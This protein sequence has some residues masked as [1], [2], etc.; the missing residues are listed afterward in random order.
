MNRFGA[1]IKQYLQPVIAGLFFLVLIVGSSGCSNP[2]MRTHLNAKP[3]LSL[4]QFFAGQTVAYGIFEDRF[5]ALKR[6]FRVQITGTEADGKLILDEDFL[7]DDGEQAKRVWTITPLGEDENGFTQY[8]GEAGD[9]KGFAQ[10]VVAGNVLNWS[11]ILDL[12]IGSQMIEVRFEDFIYQMSDNLAIN[13]AHVTKWG[14]EL[15]TVTLVFLRGELA[16][17]ALPLELQ[18]W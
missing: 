15:G 1:G 9:V 18:V 3:Q 17:T 12:D 13:R 7:Y 5:G 16:Q 2:D 11:Y 10:G 14:I 6:Q 4:E 8:R